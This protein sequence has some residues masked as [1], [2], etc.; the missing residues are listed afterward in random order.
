MT[1]GTIHEHLAQAGVDVDDDILDADL[2]DLRE[3]ELIELSGEIGDGHYC[4]AVPLMADWISSS[5]MLTWWLAARGPKRRKKLLDRIFPIQG[6]PV[7]AMLGREALMKKVLG[8]YQAVPAHWQVVGPRFAG[9][10]VILH[11]LARRLGAAGA[12][13]GG[14]DLGRWAPNAV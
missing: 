13:Y 6:T 2:A 12:L 10:T 11:E 3:L 1:F 8:L 9:K 7:P 4:L 14:V 5:R